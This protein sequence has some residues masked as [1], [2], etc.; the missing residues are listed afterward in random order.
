MMSSQHTIDPYTSKYSKMVN[1]HPQ[2]YFLPTP[3]SHSS[4]IFSNNNF[5]AYN[6]NLNNPYPFFSGH[7][8]PNSSA[9]NN[10]YLSDLILQGGG[11]NNNS[12]FKQPTSGQYSLMNAKPIPGPIPIDLGLYKQNKK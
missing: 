8:T 4:N 9:S 7:N 1:S 5:M 11:N 3:N 6:T 12:N 10:P 2:N